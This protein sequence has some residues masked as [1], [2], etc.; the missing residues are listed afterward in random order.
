MTAPAFHEAW[1]AAVEQTLAIGGK[2]A[3]RGMLVAERIAPQ[4]RF[5]GNR[6][7]LVHPHRGLNYRFAVAEWLWMTCAT[8]AVEPL[9]RYNSQMRRF[10]DDG[11]TLTGAYGPR[12][13]AHGQWEYVVDT[14]LR[15]PDSRQA[16]ITI[17]TPSPRP[18]KDVPCTVAA[19]FLLRDGALIGNWTMRSNDLWLGLPYDAFSFAR[20]TACVA[21]ILRV[22]VGDIIVTAGSSHLYEEHWG[23]AAECVADGHLASSLVTPDVCGF[24][25]KALQHVLLTGDR[26][27]AERG[28]EVSLDMAWSGYRAVLESP[29]SADALDILRGMQS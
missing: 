27:T 25:P 9:A 22:P 4:I 7:L 28:R 13:A 23:K 8:P 19:Q 2:V 29:N 1:L 20:L 16:V 6:P 10:S 26:L 15:D 11:Y 14:L 21:G 5:D 12:M 24:P 18:S 17:W 3:P